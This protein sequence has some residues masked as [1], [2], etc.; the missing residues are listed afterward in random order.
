MTGVFKN[1]LNLFLE[2]A[3]KTAVSCLGE[4]K[5]FKYNYILPPVS[6]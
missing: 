4:K 2:F 1:K 5:T 3:K 6:F